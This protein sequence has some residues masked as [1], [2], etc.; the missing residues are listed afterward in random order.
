MNRVVVWILG[1]ISGIILFFGIVTLFL[2]AVGGYGVS[3]SCEST[4]INPPPCTPVL[5]QVTV[6]NSIGN[7]ASAAGLLLLLL[8]ILVGLPAWIG[9]PILARRR[10]SSSRAAILVVSIL[11]SALVIVSV[12]STFFSPAFSTPETCIGSANPQICVYGAQ[13]TLLAVLGVGLPTL[14]VSLLVGMPAWVMALTETSQRR[15]WGWFIAALLFSPIA[16]ML[17][18]FFGARREPLTAAPL[19]TVAAS[20]G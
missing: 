8:A 15:R 3:S 18:G 5:R 4:G 9:S 12:A 19:P 20:G 2:T 16:A 13:A 10:G 17:Y 6:F 11:A 7:G 1:V 14:L